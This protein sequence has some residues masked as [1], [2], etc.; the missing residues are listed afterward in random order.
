M[1]KRGNAATVC[2]LIQWVNGT[3]ED[4]TWELYD[5]IAERFP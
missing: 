1:A 5:D 3:R 2:V 4:A